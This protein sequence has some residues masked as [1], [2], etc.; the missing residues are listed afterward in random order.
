MLRFDS[1]ARQCVAESPA[2]RVSPEQFDK[3]SGIR[4]WPANELAERVIHARD[5][6][7]W[8]YESPADGPSFRDEVKALL[9]Q[10]AFAPR[11]GMTLADQARLSYDRFQLLRERLDLRLRDVQERPARLAT[12]LELVGVV[13]A[14]LF[15]VMNIHYSLCGGTLLRHLPGCPE[16]DSYVRELD[17]GETIGAFL[18]T[19][20]GYGNNVISLQTRAD[21]D[22]DRDELVLSTPCPEARKFM[23]NTALPGVPKLGVVMA[24]LFVQGSDCGIFPVVARLRTR[25][26]VCPGVSIVP[27]GDKAGFSL[28]NAI[29]SFAGVRLPRHCLLL[30]EHRGL[31][32]VVTFWSNIRG[33]RAR[34]LRSIEQVHLGRLA[35][36]GVG[37]TAT[38]ASAFI[39]IK[40]GEQRR[41]FAPG[42]PD[43][44]V[45]EYRNHQRDLFSALAQAYASR[46]LLDVAISAHGST[47]S[48]DHDYLFRISAATKAHVTYA[49]ER[50]VRLCRERCG[51]AGMFEENRL[52][53]YATQAQGLVTAEGDNQIILIKIARQMLLRRGY[54]RLRPTRN[55]SASPL[56]EP[57]RLLQLL[58]ERER[59]LLDELRSLVARAR[60]KNQELFKLW[61]ENI[62]LAIE[63]ALAHGSRLAAEAFAARLSDFDDAHPVVD[64]FRLFAL[65]ELT[66]QLGFYLAEGLIS[67][68]ELKEH[69]ARL[70]ALCGRLRPF[71]LE[72]ASACDVPN[73][74]LRVPLASDNYVDYYDQLARGAQSSALERS[75]RGLA[76]EPGALQELASSITAPEAAPLE[77]PP[78]ETPPLETPPLEL[79]RGRRLAVNSP[80]SSIVHAR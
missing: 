36:S 77:T 6:T 44:S 50:Y 27:L 67:R 72:L 24:R 49:T 18:M 69:G 68:Q 30:G 17:S 9:S 11:P 1:A 45:L 55:H 58:R 15:T 54:V 28:D 56:S 26:E 47:D 37:A 22:Q 73:E 40:Y 31:R 70:N 13:D 75:L 43:V 66:P 19:E 23:P 52:A 42:R 74:L 41:T 57:A 63:T 76:A 33:R 32:A 20:L 80:R 39:A 29:T 8:L 4:A 25:S 65:Q 7:H 10:R 59:R 12:A 62:N 5:I 53:V 60:M 14:T 35:L 2:R 51:A 46:L 16:L 78:L 48:D 64:L 3:K 38:G 79:T 61:N 71:A 21:Y 34:F